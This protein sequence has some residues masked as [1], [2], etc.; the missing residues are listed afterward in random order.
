VV[1]CAVTMGGLVSLGAC[2]V[3][4]LGQ[5]WHYGRKSLAWSARDCRLSH[6]GQMIAGKAMQLDALST[7]RE[8]LRDQVHVIIGS[9]DTLLVVSTLMLATGF[10][11]VVEGSYPSQL[12]DR[13]PDQQPWLVVYSCLMAMSLIFPFWSVIFT[14]RVR[15]EVD[16]VLSNFVQHLRQALSEIIR[17]DEPLDFQ[18]T[19]TEDEDPATTLSNI[20]GRFISA[21]SNRHG[22]EVVS[23]RRSTKSNHA[24]P[25]VQT[26]TL[27]DILNWGEKELL[28][29]LT[30]YHFYYPLAQI[31]LWL[32][33]CSSLLVC[34][35]LLGLYFSDTYPETPLMWKSYSSIVAVNSFLS[36][37]FLVGVRLS[38]RKHTA[39]K[40]ESR[41]IRKQDIAE[42]MSKVGTEQL[43][44]PPVHSLSEP[45]LQRHDMLISRRSI[46]KSN[47]LDS[48]HLDRSRALLPDPLPQHPGR[49]HP[50]SHAPG[51]TQTSSTMP[52]E[53]F[54]PQTRLSRFPISHCLS[55]VER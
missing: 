41:M 20:A 23:K 49:F 5:Q 31:F 55:F 38:T 19:L 42:A 33:M 4:N 40:T 24:E 30:Q 6:Q 44:T 18:F 52:D 39:E 1:F 26:L 47:T 37:V 51:R 43:R 35:V 25:E 28:K 50:G 45:L 16:D 12:A 10:G 46:R 17:Q 14:L 32:G 15:H 54:V 22:T 11:F 3:V 36:L 27:A 53:R 21:A 9:L 8:E 13:D 48:W 7:V 29:N 2:D 34:S